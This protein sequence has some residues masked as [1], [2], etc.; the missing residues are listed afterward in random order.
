MLRV[1]MLGELALELD[2]TRMDP[3]G[4]RRARSL[5]G[6][7]ALDRRMH[8]R[9]DLA[10]RFWPD[11]LDE[12]ARTSLRAALSAL[13]RSLGPDAGRYLLADRERAGLTDSADVWTDAADF[14]RLV[15]EGRL[16]EAVELWR[17]DLLSG[18]DDEWVLGARDEWRDRLGGVLA[19]L[20][21]NAEAAGD[22]AHAV[23]HTRRIVA[24]DPLSEEPQGELIRRLAA[25]GDRAAALAAYARFADRL[26][27]ELRIVP[28]QSTRALVEE[29]RHE[30]EPAPVAVAEPVSPASGTVTLLFTDLVGSTEL[31]E[32]LGD[33]E[34]ERLRR[35]H[36]TL[37]ATWR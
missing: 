21:A 13:R 28:S 29:I 25:A 10:A 20:A 7:L 23:A 19:R 3:P 11:V 33:E 26:R 35:V 16:A 37:L 15:E 12:S 14:D 1:R 36:F 22:L 27:A 31:L 4:S 18:L 34:A 24:L 32:E 2:G 9:S 6:L 8:A 17:G 30:D 5:L